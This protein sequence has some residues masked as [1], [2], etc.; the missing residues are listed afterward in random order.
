MNSCAGY[1]ELISAYADNELSAADRQRMEGHL[2]VC[3]SCSS[4]LSMYREI[5]IAAAEATVPVPEALRISVMGRVSQ[6]AA[7]RADALSRRR[8]IIR[9]SLTRYLPIVA[10]LA[11][12]LL[13]LPRFFNIDRSTEGMTET[14]ASG[15][16][17]MDTAGIEGGGGYAFSLDTVQQESVMPGE[18]YDMDAA[19]GGGMPEPAA[20][21]ATEPESETRFYDDNYIGDA[22]DTEHSESYGSPMPPVSADG[23]TD[24]GSTD[25]STGGGFSDSQEYPMTDPPAADASIESDDGLSS[26]PEDSIGLAGHDAAGYFAVIAINAELPERFSTLERFGEEGVFYITRDEAME[27]INGFAHL[28]EELEYGDETAELAKVVIQFPR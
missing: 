17:S 22:A 8:K 27:L 12:A 24:G 28:I 10:C 13:T 26:I 7:M 25:G 14:S 3:E 11:V 5:S 19:S 15:I 18:A 9:A 4:L 20:V 1:M 21:P 2:S 23:S 6:D 16:G